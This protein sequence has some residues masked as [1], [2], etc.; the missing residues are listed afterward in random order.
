MIEN[1]RDIKQLCQQ[2]GIDPFDG[3]QLLK[4]SSLS[5]KQIDQSSHV[6]IQC[7]EPFDVKKLSD[8]PDDYR[9]AIISDNLQWLT[10]KD[11]ES[12]Q[13][14][15]DL[16]YLPALERDAQ[17][18]RFTT[19][20]SYMDEI[21]EKDMWA[22]EQTHESLLPYLMEEAEEVAVAIA[23]NDQDNLVEELGDILLQVFY[24]AGYA[25]LESLFTM[26]DILDTL[27]KK[28][29]RRHPHVFDGYVVNT[30]QDID[31]MWQAIKRKEKE[32]RENNEIR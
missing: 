7:D 27:N 26:A 14:I 10:V 12:N 8:Y 28:L 21:L 29:R 18:K 22:R 25:K 32:M 4:S 1:K 17:T 13:I 9:L 3:L 31:D 16:L 5:V 20:Q 23:N 2:L 30:I 19:T 6:I 11:S 15:G 24:H